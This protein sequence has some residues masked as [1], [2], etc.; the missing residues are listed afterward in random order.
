MRNT[1]DSNNREIRMQQKFI[2]KL[3]LYKNEAKRIC[4]K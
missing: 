3:F 2:L 4:D 1:K